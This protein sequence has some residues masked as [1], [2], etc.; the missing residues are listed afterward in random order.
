VVPDVERDSRGAALSCAVL[1]DYFH[2]EDLVGV[3][4]GCGFGVSQERHDPVLKGA[5][6][7]VR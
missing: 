3:F 7:G 2:L 5:D 6:N 1:A 4:V